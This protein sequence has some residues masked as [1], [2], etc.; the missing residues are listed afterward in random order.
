[1]T[2]VHPAVPT[3]RVSPE[4]TPTTTLG[5]ASIADP[6]PLGLAAFAMTTF[7]LSFANTGLFAAEPVVFGLAFFY[8]GI[9]QLLAGMWEF[10]KG[11]TFGATAFTS[12]GAFW[13]SFWYLTNH[14]DLTGVSASE[15]SHGIGLYLL[16][17][18]IFTAYM[19]VASLRTNAALMTV[20]GLLTLTF[21]ALALGD[22]TTTDGLHKLGGWLG[23]ATAIAAWYTSFA[24]VT[25]S[26]YK[27]V[28][29]PVG[30]R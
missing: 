18:T 16:A 26:T 12:Y 13:L 30:A 22:L 6:G 4:T 9:A 7:V 24:V 11:N 17:W 28:V 21:L 20:F 10:V 5:L 25:N 2:A 15:A 8:G 27:R 14:T 29:L 19:L 1:M 23:L 3:S